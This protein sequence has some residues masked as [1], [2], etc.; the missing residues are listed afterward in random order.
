[1]DSLALGRD[2]DEWLA[3]RIPVASYARVSRDAAGD[4]RGVGRQ[5]LNNDDAATELGWAVVYR[6]TDN[7]VT[8]SD[9]LVERPAFLHLLR[10]LRS[11]R[12]IEAFPVCGVIA[13]EEE[14][15]ARLQDDYALL[16]RAL[17]MNED[18]CLYLVD[19]M[20]LV[21]VAAELEV[22]R[23]RNPRET[24]QSESERT[25]RRRR[26]SVRD[27]AHEGRGSGGQ[28]RFGW[29]GPDVATGRS[30]NTL[31]D[32][33]ES[34]YLRS[35]IDM[36]LA[37]ASWSAIADWLT[38][39]LVPTV[40]GSRWA[41]DTVQSMV[42][43]PAICGYRMVSGELVRDRV[44]GRPVVGGWQTVAVPEEWLQ[45]VE[46][47]DRWHSPDRARLTYKQAHASRLMELGGARSARER[48]EEADR[49]RKY[50]LSGFLR[51]GYAGDGGSICG[52]KMGGQPPRGTNKR[53]SYRCVAAKCRKVGRRSDLVDAHVEAVALRVLEERYRDAAPDES[54][55]PSEEQLA[56][57]RAYENPSEVTRIQLRDL[58]EDRKDF[59]AQ[60]A[61]RNLLARFT[62]ERWD[63]YDIRQKRLA[64]AAVVESVVIRP[65]PKDRTRN[66][67]FD[68][69]LI[70]VRFK[71]W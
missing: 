21:D 56:L 36:A 67:P 46:R 35:A 7:G 4:G 33:Y 1:M 37:G 30:T 39:E 5:H 28:R 11:R 71:E 42:T 60:Q 25:S 34:M 14:R 32:P 45:L 17:A 23:S 68:P 26:R 48:R 51:C 10:S 13:V 24:R 64:L 44:S 58:E 49:G 53:P 12:T 47:C 70:E 69:T 54:A 16:C 62:G 3:G 66:A 22:P 9:P 2:V 63:S 59:Y 31:L 61:D 40:R 20:Q 65:I 15:L 19:A 18:G 57:L 38:E 55:F 50:L 43:N 41:V 29:Y 52:C 8:A 27:H 6:F